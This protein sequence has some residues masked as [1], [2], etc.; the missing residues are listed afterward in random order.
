M[1]LNYTGI[2]YSNENDA[3]KPFSQVL[4]KPF[5]SS[6]A[7]FIDAVFMRPY[8]IEIFNIE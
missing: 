8:I 3:E 7:L 6:E 1:A 5:K 4:N 2:K